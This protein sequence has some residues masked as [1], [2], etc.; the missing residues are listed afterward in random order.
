MYLNIYYE[1]GKEDSPQSYIHIWDDKL[2][3]KK[4]PYQK[5]AY[6]LD[7]NGD[8]TTL[9]GQP[10][11]LVKRWKKDDLENGLIFES[12]IHPEMRYLVDN[13]TTSETPSEAHIV[14][15]F[16]IEVST[17]G[18]LPDIHKA[19][20]PI[21]AIAYHDSSA[22]HYIVHLLDPSM[23]MSDMTMTQRGDVVHVKCHPT[24]EE[25]LNEFLLEYETIK[26]TVL[27]G[28]NID[29]FDI[30]YL[31][32]RLKNVFDNPTAKRLSP[33]GRV[34]YNT[35]RQRYFIAGVSCLDM[36][37]LYKNFTFGER[38]SYSLDA[39]AKIEVGEGKIEYSGTLDKL[40]EEDK[41]KFID[42]NVHDVR[43][44]KM[45]DD[46]MKLILLAKGICHKGHVPLEDF[47]FSSRFLD[48]A[49]LTYLKRK[50]KIVVPNKPV[51]Q[52]DYEHSDDPKFDGAY[53]KEPIPGMYSWL[54]D[55]DA[56]SMYPSIIMT[57]NIS[58]ETKV[59][60][61]AEWNNADFQKN[62]DRDYIISLADDNLKFD[63]NEFKKFIEQENLG[64]SSNGVLYELTRKGIIP[65]ILEVW[66]DE[67]T[68]MKNLV[69]KHGK[70]LNNDGSVNTYYDKDK[71]EFYNARQKIQKTLLNSL[72]GV[73]G[74]T[75]F[76]YYDLD[77]A[78]AV[79]TTGVDLIKF[80]QSV[81]NMYFNK[82]LKNKIH[83]ELETGKKLMLNEND[84]VLVKRN[85][86]NIKI[87]AKDILETD[88]FEEILHIY[89]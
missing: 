9:Y 3:Y 77:N 60:R 14:M 64:V 12:D 11:K 73:L 33:I 20:N 82:R 58:P 86:I 22:K 2:G 53:V 76:R 1:A 19:E 71:L 35:Y 57:L 83:I 69:K 38:S 75:S 88:D 61:L 29:Y 21:T 15:N 44:V 7:P 79:T 54:V 37:L 80:A 13:Y 81:T 25:L 8:Y 16:D 56:T 23:Q 52:G 63:K 6:K 10:C 72:Y 42:Y 62:V 87:K 85:N 40:Y 32:N 36:I 43:L 70:E 46:K 47:Q 5:Y 31:Y 30:P 84:D 55:L 66:F 26:P 48:G 18:G 67:R 34:F 89:M 51:K 59:T 49:I 65:E 39:I 74:L 45:I 24:E 50:G 17:D 68:E 28:W 41:E 27:T 78:E 4:I